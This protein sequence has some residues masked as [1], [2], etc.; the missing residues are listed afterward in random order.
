MQRPPGIALDRLPALLQVVRHVHWLDST[1]LRVWE[2]VLRA[3]I[4]EFLLEEELDTSEQAT[5]RVP[6]DD[7]NNRCM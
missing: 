1:R 3:S 4:A 7:P 2:S 5:A 6:R